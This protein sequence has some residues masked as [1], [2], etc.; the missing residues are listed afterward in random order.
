MNQDY[1][2][3]NLCVEKDIEDSTCHGCCQLE[4]KLNDQKEQ[5]SDVPAPVN[6]KV[7]INLFSQQVDIHGFI[8]ELSLVFKCY[9]QNNYSLIITNSVFHP[10]KKV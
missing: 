5:K 4:K 3:E 9:Y 1:I 7:D 8:S 2:A 10:P 6:N